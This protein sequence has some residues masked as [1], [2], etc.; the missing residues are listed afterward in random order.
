MHTSKIISLLCLVLVF[1]LSACEDKKK[2]ETENADPNPAQPGFDLAGSDQ[3]AVEVANQVMEAMGGRQAWDNTRYI[4]W[5]FFGRRHHFWDKWTGDVRIEVPSDTMTI[6]MNIHTNDGRI[7]KSGEIISHPDSVSDYIK[8]G[9]RMW[10][11]DSY[12]LAMPFKLK[13][14]GVTLKYLGERKSSSGQ[15]SQVLEISFNNVGVTPENRYEI[16]VND[17]SKLVNEW[18]FFRSPESDTAD[19]QLPWLDY[20]E[21]GE[22]LLSGNRGEYE[23]T[24]IAVYDSLPPSIFESFKKPSI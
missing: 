15:K 7:K 19:F 14:S 5:N 2:S 13:D 4:A 8:L 23:L 9:K 11:N 21:H 18:A 3:K 20:E 12:W 6:L 10:I 24:E 22:I 16:Y 17:S 1:A